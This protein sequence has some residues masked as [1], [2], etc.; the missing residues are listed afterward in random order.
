[1]PQIQVKSAALDEWATVVVVYSVPG[2]VLC[3]TTDGTAPDL[4]EDACFASGESF[5]LSAPGWHTVVVQAFSDRAPFGES[6]N[7][8]VFIRGTLTPPSPLYLVILITSA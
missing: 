6:V 7:E 4:N 2:A 8:R 5:I 3:I 1:M